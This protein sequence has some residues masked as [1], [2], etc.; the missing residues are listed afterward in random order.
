MGDEAPGDRT[1]AV[2]HH[3]R[4]LMS[5]ARVIGQGG[6][7]STLFERDGVVAS[8]MPEVPDRSVP[9]SVAYRD[10]DALA[11][12]LEEVAGAYESA[13][14]RAWTVWVPE[15]DRAAAALLDEAG[16]RLDATPAAMIAELSRLPEPDPD[17]L[18]WDAL[19][20][21]DVVARIN[22]HA[23][24][25]TT[26]GGFGAAMAR[27]GAIDGL[28]LY[29]ARIGGEPASV[30][31]TYDNGKDCEVY[32]LATLTE[33]RGKGLA[34]RLLHRA[35]MEARDRGLEVSSLQATKMGYPV[36]KRL[37]YEPIC[38]LEMWERR[39]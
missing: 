16:H 23:Y 19:A 18:D 3:R 37:G 36:Y 34:R 21:A 20:Q 8:V 27:F 9:N 32:F 29:Q 12:A 17:E 6:E 13:G 7:S 4:A 22:N 15:D 35:L 5:F 31:G 28:R 11:A 38:T 39:T 24:G 1:A 10:A 14:V 33:Y 26:G 25:W 2:A 30:L